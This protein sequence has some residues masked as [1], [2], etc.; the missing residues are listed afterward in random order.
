MTVAWI[1]LVNCMLPQ[2]AQELTYAH[3]ILNRAVLSRGSV[4]AMLAAEAVPPA[5]QQ[6]F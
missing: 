3:Q 1:F 4:R 6:G 5:S 2:H